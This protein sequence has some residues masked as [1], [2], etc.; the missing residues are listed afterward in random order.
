MIGLTAKMV[1]RL[2]R[3]KAQCGASSNGHDF[4][5]HVKSEHRGLHR[6]GHP[7]AAGEHMGL[8]GCVPG[9]LTHRGSSICL[10]GIDLPHA[11]KGSYARHT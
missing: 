11:Q 2:C 3:H 8:L 6:M 5:R 10:I 1:S 9:M 4:M 7:T